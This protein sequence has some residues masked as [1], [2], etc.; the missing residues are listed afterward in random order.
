MVKFPILLQIPLFDHRIYTPHLPLIIYLMASSLQHRL[1]CSRVTWRDCASRTNIPEQVVTSWFW[2]LKN[3]LFLS[4]VNGCIAADSS[5]GRRKSPDIFSILSTNNPTPMN[6]ASN[7]FPPSFPLSPS[8]LGLSSNLTFP[9][10]SPLSRPC[11]NRPFHYPAVPPDRFKGASEINQHPI[12]SGKSI[13]MC[14]RDWNTNQTDARAWAYVGSGRC[15][16]SHLSTNRSESNSCD[17][18]KYYTRIKYF[19]L[20]LA[21]YTGRIEVI[22]SRN[23]KMR[24]KR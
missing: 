8:C 20:R 13:G 19:G 1:S 23:R 5:L 6:R 16:I 15:L 10:F 14:S 7:P 9:A 18:P 11:H 22:A 4:L 17:T 2:A 24:K 21:M 12:S 3:K